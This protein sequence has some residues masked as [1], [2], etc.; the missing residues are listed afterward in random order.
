MQFQPTRATSKWGVL[1]PEADPEEPWN[2]GI[3]NWAAANEALAL[4]SDKDWQDW[5][6]GGTIAE[7]VCRMFSPG[8]HSSWESFA[9]TSY[10]TEGGPRP[11]PNNPG[12][13]SL[14]FI[15]NK[16]HVSFSW[17]KTRWNCSSLASELDRR[18]SD[19]NRCRSYEYLRL[20]CVWST[21][22]ASPLVKFFYPMHARPYNWW[23]L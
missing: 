15:H 11:E 18:Y 13:L 9:S 23:R 10:K 2:D 6:A 17:L 19:Y 3:Q 20:C 16:I 7:A 14:E 1:T 21:L 4:R 22:L 8:Y 5:K 12:Y